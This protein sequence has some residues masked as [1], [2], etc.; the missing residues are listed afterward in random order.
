MSV[1]VVACGVACVVVVVWC[2][3]AGARK[4]QPRFSTCVRLSRGPLPAPARHTC[5]LSVACRAVPQSDVPRES[6]VHRGASPIPRGISRQVGSAQACTPARATGRGVRDDPR[7]AVTWHDVPTTTG[8]I[9]PRYVRCTCTR[10]RAGAVHRRPP[11][12]MCHRSRCMTMCA[13]RGVASGCPP[14]PV[15]IAGRGPVWRR[16]VARRGARARRGGGDARRRFFGPGT[17]DRRPPFDHSPMTPEPR[18]DR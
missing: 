6:D 3:V 8:P 7:R 9:V 12:T 4:P 16:F 11:L 5:P 13:G 15:A 14:V 2:T 18:Y 10:C 1:D 17:R